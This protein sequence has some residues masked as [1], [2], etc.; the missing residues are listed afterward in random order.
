[1]ALKNNQVKKSIDADLENVLK[2]KSVSNKEDKV[3]ATKTKETKKSTNKGEVK[4]MNKEVK[5]ADT[6]LMEAVKMNKDLA[7]KSSTLH[8]VTLLGLESK[9]SRR[10]TPETYVKCPTTVGV[11]L[12]TDIAIKVPV[13]DVLKNKDTGIEPSDISWKSVKAG[14]TFNLNMYELMYLVIK[15]EYSGFITR[16]GDDKG[17]Y[18]APKMSSFNSGKSKL[19]TPAL[20]FKN[21]TGSI[22]ESM[23]VIDEQ[24]NGQW[25]VKA[26]YKEQ[27]GSLLERKVRAKKESTP[28]PMLTALALQEL[29]GVNQ[30]V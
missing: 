4:E 6:K 27:F 30:A 19:P 22:K 10:K 16:N 15:P 28:A 12:K 26:E 1:M 21:G 14:E 8:F 7:S 18:F 17:V 2:N 29:L 23:L 11:T 25:E 3:M 9:K 5:L 20:A 13:I 24:V